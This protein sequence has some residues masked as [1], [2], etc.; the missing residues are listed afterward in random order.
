MTAARTPE[1]PRARLAALSREHQ[2]HDR[3]RQRRADAD[4]VRADQVQLQRREVGFG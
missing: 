4:A 1:W 2:P 3:R